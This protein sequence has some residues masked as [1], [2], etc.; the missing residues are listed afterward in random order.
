MSNGSNVVRFPVQ[1]DR[2]L[3][4]QYAKHMISCAIARARH[5][6][7]NSEPLSDGERRVLLA[8]MEQAMNGCATIGITP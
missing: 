7:S 8:L 1:N 2:E 5:R 3:E 4:E 6:L